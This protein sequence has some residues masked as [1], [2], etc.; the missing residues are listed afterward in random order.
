M[1]SCLLSWQGISKPVIVDPQVT[2]VN[3]DYYT[4]HVKNDLVPAL[5]RFYPLNDGIFV[6]DGASSH[7]S[8]KCQR[9]LSKEFGKSRKVSKKQWPPQ[10]PDLNPLDYFFWAEVQSKVFEARREPFK[11]QQELEAQILRVWESACNKNFTRKAIKQFRPRLLAVVKAKG[12]PI[13]HLFK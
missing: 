7:T 9:F 3:A 13:K 8:N 1:V 4:A 2:K 12:G 11:D 10:S 6:Q 5:K